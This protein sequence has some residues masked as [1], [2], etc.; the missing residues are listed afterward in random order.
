MGEYKDQDPPKSLPS[1]PIKDSHQLQK[2]RYTPINI[3]T[4]NTRSLS[5]DEKLLE[6]ETAIESIKWDILGIS[7]MRRLGEGIEDHEDYIL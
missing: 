3:S 7:E 5:T 2:Q 4:F 6:L 1:L